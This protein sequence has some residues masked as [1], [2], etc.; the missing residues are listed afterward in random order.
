MQWQ[1][2]VG[3]AGLGKVATPPNFHRNGIESWA[4]STQA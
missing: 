2:F 3:S 4:T 1:V